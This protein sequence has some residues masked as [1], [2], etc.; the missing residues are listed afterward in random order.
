VEFACCSAKNGKA[1][2]RLDVQT[3][4]AKAPYNKVAW[5]VAK[6]QRRLRSCRRRCEDLCFR[7]YRGIVEAP[8][9]PTASPDFL[10]LD[11]RGNRS[12]LCLEQQLADQY[13]HASALLV[14]TGMMRSRPNL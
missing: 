10:D 6:N 5:S 13:A 11:P 7:D 3:R 2:R 4:L 8:R 12:V 9:R 1:I 14:S